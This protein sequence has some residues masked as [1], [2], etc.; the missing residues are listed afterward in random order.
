MA[1]TAAAEV[2]GGCGAGNGN[3]VGGTADGNNDCLSINEGVFCCNGTVVNFFV[4]GTRL[5][6][7]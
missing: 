7:F 1:A 4:A 2:I 6:G 3:D 5:A